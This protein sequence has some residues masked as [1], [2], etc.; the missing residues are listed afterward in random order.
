MNGADDDFDALQDCEDPQ[1]MS[2][3]GP[4]DCHHPFGQPPEGCNGID[5]GMAA[6]FVGGA[7]DEVACRCLNDNGCDAL[8]AGAVP[9]YVCHDDIAGGGV[10]GPLCS[11]QDWCPSRGL[12]CEADHRC[13]SP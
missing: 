12:V 11:E 6:G 9:A 7:I 8:Q 10:C 2:N 1:C 13:H 4:G 5:D 3:L